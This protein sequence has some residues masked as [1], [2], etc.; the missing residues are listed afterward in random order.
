M[1]MIMEFIAFLTFIALAVGV[2]RCSDKEAL[3][4]QVKS[5]RPFTLHGEE[6]V[7]SYTSRQVEIKMLQEQIVKLKGE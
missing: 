4:H 1:K 6:W 2:V 5:S 7:C 3:Q